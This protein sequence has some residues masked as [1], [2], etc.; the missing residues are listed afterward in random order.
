M[1]KDKTVSKELWIRTR[2]RVK[3]YGQ[4]QDREKRTMDKN[5]S[6]SKEL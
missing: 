4:G 3:N 2:H 6:E 1:E 5:Q